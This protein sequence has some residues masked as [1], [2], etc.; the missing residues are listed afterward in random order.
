[1]LTKEN[2]QDHIDI[3]DYNNKFKILKIIKN[4]FSFINKENNKVVYSDIKFS[5]IEFFTKII[6]LFKSNSFDFTYKIINNL[7]LPDG[8]KEF[9][10]LFIDSNDNI[11]NEI[12]FKRRIVGLTSYFRS[13]QEQ[14]M[15][16]YNEDEDLELINIEMSEHQFNVYADARIKEMTAESKKMKQ[17][18]KKNKVNN[19]KIYS[20]NVSTYRLFSRM[21]C[22]FVFPDTIKRP[23]PSKGGTIESTLDSVA[24]SETLDETFVDDVNIDEKIEASDNKLED[25]DS[26]KIEKELSESKTHNYNELIAKAYNQLDIEGSQYL[27]PESLKDLSP[28]FLNIL[29]NLKEPDLMGIHL[30]YSQFKTL[31]GI[32][33]FKLVLKHNGF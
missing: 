2:V 5:T 27:V 12:L 7:A 4:P 30:L 29:E 28:K 8:F 18:M 26:P 15:P 17:L 9:K 10:E 1:M 13:A 19:D 3:I 23:I 25:S 21:C 6:D 32:G 11:R 24:D 31:E 16:K 33:I 14:L 20:E 22:N